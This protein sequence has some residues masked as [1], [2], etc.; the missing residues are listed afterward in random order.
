V[1]KILKIID[2]NVNITGNKQAPRSGAF[3][4]TLNNKLIFSKFETGTFPDKRIIKNWFN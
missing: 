2:P 3:E 1:S 4:V